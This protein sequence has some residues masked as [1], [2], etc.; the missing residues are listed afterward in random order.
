MLTPDEVVDL[1]TLMS[2]LNSRCGAALPLAKEKGAVKKHADAFF[3]SYPNA[4]WRALTDLANW[5]NAKGK[6][7]NMIKLVGSWRYAYE[8]GYMR[9]LDRG[10]S[11]NDDRTLREMLKNVAD[12]H[13][14]EQMM[15][16]ATATA[17]NEIYETYHRSN[18]A[19]DVSPGQDDPLAEY[20]LATGQAVKVRLTAADI[21]VVGTAIGL[22]DKR[23]L[24]YL[25]GEEV[26]I[27]FHLV[28]VREDGEWSNLL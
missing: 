28:Q 17:R 10:N 1:K 3:E 23:L 6:H 9:I 8:D 24:V 4:E 21:P 2:Y 19:A 5:A 26:P 22:D 18:E 20:G 25:K 13:V 11:T 12:P 14:R 7:L 16:A 15:N 27:P